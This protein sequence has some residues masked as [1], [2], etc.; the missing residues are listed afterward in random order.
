MSPCIRCEHLPDDR[1]L[2]AVGHRGCVRLSVRT[3][4]ECCLYAPKRSKL[5]GA[6]PGESR[7]G[8]VVFGVFL[9]ENAMPVSKSVV[10]CRLSMAR[11]EAECPI[12]C[13]VGSAP[14]MHAGS[15]YYRNAN[16]CF[17]NADLLTSD[18]HGLII[19]LAMIAV[20]S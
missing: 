6:P 4:L 1:S 18:A 9:L 7:Q 17:E 12:D 3:M 16:L 8:K 2:A 19:G 14:S 11:T 20:R 13:I 10:I 5:Q 15:M